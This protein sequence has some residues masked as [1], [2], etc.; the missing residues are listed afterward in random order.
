MTSSFEG[1]KGLAEE[2][3]TEGELKVLLSKE[4][5]K[6]GYVGIEPSGLMHTGHLILSGMVRKLQDAGV[7]MDILL[8][9][10]HAYINDKLG[11]KI[12][13]IRVCGKYMEDAFIAMG[14]DA[15]KTKFVYASE[16]IG[17]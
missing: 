5:L 15:K 8:A 9:D 17:D 13:D 1:I 7:Q 3:V 14:V 4:G 16:Y 10:W 11:G 6:K 2:I 12:E